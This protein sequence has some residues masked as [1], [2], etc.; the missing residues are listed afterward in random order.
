MAGTSSN[1]EG[2]ILKADYEPDIS[3]VIE[4]VLEGRVS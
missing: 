4:S 3:L 1:D 2:R